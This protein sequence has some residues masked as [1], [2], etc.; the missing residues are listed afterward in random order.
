MRMICLGQARHP[1]F[2]RGSVAT[3]TVL[4]H[5]MDVYRQASKEHSSSLKIKNLPAFHITDKLELFFA[6]AH[7]FVIFVTIVICNPGI[8][9]ESAVAS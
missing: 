7:L 2:Q 8:L 9:G 6:N 4:L 5:N 1:H 3:E